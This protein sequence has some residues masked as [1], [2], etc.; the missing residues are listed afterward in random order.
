MTTPYDPLAQ[1]NLWLFTQIVLGLCAT[2]DDYLHDPDVDL[3]TLRD[4][5]ER[6]R[7]YAEPIAAALRTHHTERSTT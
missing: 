2:V 4:R 6:V 5:A 7:A 3:H 1:D